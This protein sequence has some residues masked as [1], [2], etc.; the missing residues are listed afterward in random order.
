MDERRGSEH[1]AVSAIVDFSR[2]FLLCRPWQAELPLGTP[3]HGDASLHRRCYLLN[4]RLRPCDSREALGS[5]AQCW[6][7]LQNED[8]GGA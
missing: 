5:R 6:E 7:G 2:A 8:E 3:V 4:S 1:Q